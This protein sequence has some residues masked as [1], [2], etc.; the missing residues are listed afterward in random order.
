MSM[1]ED[2]LVRARALIGASGRDPADF[3][4]EVEYMEPDPDGAGMFTVQYLVTILNTRTETGL[5]AMGGIGSDWVGDF[6]QELDAGY[7]D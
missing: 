2:E 7:F 4:F 6:K 1:Y 5:R 3:A